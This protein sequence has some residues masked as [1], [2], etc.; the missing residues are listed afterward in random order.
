MDALSGQRFQESEIVN[1]A[2]RANEPE[3]RD[4]SGLLTGL[5]FGG[6]AGF[7]AMLLFA[8]QSGKQ[9][10]AQIRQKSAELQDRTTDT[11]DDLVTLSHFDNRKILSGTRR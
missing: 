7:G 3:Q 11:F 1:H 10:R 4:A 8:P 2:I 5:L 9:T 6:L